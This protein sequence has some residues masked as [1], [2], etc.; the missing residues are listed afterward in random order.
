MQGKQTGP[1]DN[2]TCDKRNKEERKGR[3]DWKWEEARRLFLI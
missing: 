1:K 3:R 2:K